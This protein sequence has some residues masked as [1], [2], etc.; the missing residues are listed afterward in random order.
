MGW[1]VPALVAGTVQS[2]VHV[3]LAEDLAPELWLYHGGRTEQDLYDV[4]FS[5][6][7]TRARRSSKNRRRVRPDCQG[8]TD[9]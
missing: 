9:Q 3:A 6:I 7:S 2:T 8:V 4:E 1:T 5:A